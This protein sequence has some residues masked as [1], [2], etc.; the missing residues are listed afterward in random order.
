VLKED[1][2][3]TDGQTVWCTSCRAAPAHSSTC[4]L[5]IQMWGCMWASVTHFTYLSGRLC[6]VYCRASE[7]SETPSGG[8]RRGMGD[9]TSGAVVYYL[10]WVELYASMVTI[11][12]AH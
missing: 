1:G 4:C 2:F 6:L 5:E 7:A 11:R 12:Y 9:L 8:K 10:M 3:D